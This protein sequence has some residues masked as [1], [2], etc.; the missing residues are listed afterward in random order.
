[1]DTSKA[2]IS[3]FNCSEISKDGMICMKKQGK[4]EQLKK[5]NRQWA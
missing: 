4:T 2:E 1:M 5:G 3:D